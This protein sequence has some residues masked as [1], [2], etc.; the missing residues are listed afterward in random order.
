MQAEITRKDEQKYLRFKILENPI[1]AEELSVAEII[2]NIENGSLSLEVSEDDG[3][4]ILDDSSIEEIKR[5][6]PFLL[7]IVDKPRSFIRSLEE[8]VPVETAKRINHKAIAKLSQDSNDWYARTVLSVKPKNVVSDVNEETIDLYENRFVCALI[9]RISGL[10][11]Q[12]RQYYESQIQYFDENSAQR[13][14]EY[15]YSTNSFPF[16]NTISKKRKDFSDD[17]TFRRKLEDELESIKQ[18]EKKIRLLKRSEFYRTLRKKRKVVDPIQKTNILMFEF[19]YNQ[20]YKLW[21]YLNEQHQEDRLNLELEI[22]EEESQGT[23]KVYGFLCLVATLRDMGFEEVS[24]ARLAYRNNEF[25]FTKPFVFVR[26]EDK[27]ELHL[28]K[29]GLKCRLLLDEI[30]VKY[31]E[32]VFVSDFKNFEPLSRSDVDEETRNILSRN[33][34]TQKLSPISSVYTLLSINLT[35]CSEE[36]VFSDKVYR[37]FFSIGDNFSPDERK[38]YLGKWCDYKS[39]IIILTPVNLKNNFLKLE[40]IINYH[41]LKN[42]IGNKKPEVCPICGNPIREN[43]PDNYSCH[44]CHHNISLTYCN[45][46]DPQHNKPILWIKYTDENFLQKETIVRGLAE[47]SPYYRMGKIETIMGEHSI[48]SFELDYDVGKWKLKTICPHCGIKLGDSK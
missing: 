21:K 14:M 34:P 36:N 40:R 29:E 45:D 33:L 8:K 31:D 7:K 32:F 42:K 13:E 26:G 37:R 28:C 4:K 46:C 12:A 35:R 39:G 30:K 6:V 24:E 41:I 15:T 10:L 18:I 23:Y 2:T 25:S 1:F 5:V 27:I 16:Y 3:T 47:K 38:E 22:P 43:S 17:Q 48:T 44:Y 9:S 20:A 11:S 19:N